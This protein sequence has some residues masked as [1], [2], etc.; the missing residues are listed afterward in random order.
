MD[1]LINSIKILMILSRLGQDKR[2]VLLPL[3]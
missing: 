3:V 1:E 2:K